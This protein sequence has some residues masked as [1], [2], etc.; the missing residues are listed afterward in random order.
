MLAEVNGE[1]RDGGEVMMTLS[2]WADWAAI[3][4]T[5]LAAAAATF[6]GWGGLQKPSRKEA[7]S[8]FHVCAK[9]SLTY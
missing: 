1:G 8:S 4:S 5:I 9:S 6:A 3:I 7:G 2:E